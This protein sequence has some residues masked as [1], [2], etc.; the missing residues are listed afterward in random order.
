MQ[1]K[2]CSK[3]G[4]EKELFEFHN[5]ESGK[6]GVMSKCKICVRE[7]MKLRSRKYRELNPDKVKKQ[8]KAHYEKNK[9]NIK[10]KDNEHYHLHKEQHKSAIL[11]RL[12]GIT[13]EDYNIMLESQNGVCA[14]CGK[15]E[16]LIDNRT[17]TLRA[18]AVDHDHKTEK[19]RGLLCNRC[20]K[21]LGGFK[22]NINNLLSAIKYLTK[23]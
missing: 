10:K 14:I 17:N 22:D 15:P 23:E 8:R 3:C 6:F 4:I 19:V 20:N 1:T 12:F 21:S 9:E 13:L 16:F 5:E 11:K 7:I 18:L 2:I